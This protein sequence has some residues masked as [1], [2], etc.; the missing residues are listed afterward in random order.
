MPPPRASGRVNSRKPT[1]GHAYT[2]VSDDSQRCRR[3]CRCNLSGPQSLDRAVQGLKAVL[4]RSRAA[5][6]KERSTRGTLLEH[7][8]ESLEVLP[9]DDRQ[10]WTCQYGDGATPQPPGKREILIPDEG[11]PAVA[12]VLEE[13][14]ADSGDEPAMLNPHKTAFFPVGDG[15]PVECSEWP[16]SGFTLERRSDSG[17]LHRGEPDLGGI[18]HPV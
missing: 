13:E 7:A 9:P 8:S 10:K 3:H 11:R 5:C 16:D 6:G 1:A 12:L 2:S 17:R 4:W 15:H 14:P 18:G